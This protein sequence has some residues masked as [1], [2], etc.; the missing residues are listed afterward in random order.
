LVVQRLKEFGT[1]V[2]KQN[3]VN[4]K[5]HF[6]LKGKIIFAKTL[7]YEFNYLVFLTNKN[8]IKKT[9]KELVLSFKKFPTTIMGLEPGE[10]ILAVDPVND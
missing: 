7:Q 9:L 2:M 4:L 5:A 1:F 3:A 10:K 8:S 6:G